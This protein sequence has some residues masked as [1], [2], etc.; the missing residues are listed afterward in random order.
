M[1]VVGFLPLGFKAISEIYNE[2]AGMAVMYRH[3]Q[4]LENLHEDILCV[5]PR[6]TNPN[7]WMELRGDGVALVD[8][9]GKKRLP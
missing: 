4:L 9:P 5:L 7:P 6:G 8:L 3:P 1:S 2:I